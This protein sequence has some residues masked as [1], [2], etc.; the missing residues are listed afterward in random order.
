MPTKK[1]L[2]FLYLG[3]FC[4]LPYSLQAQESAPTTASKVSLSCTV[5]NAVVGENGIFSIVKGQGVEL[6]C[7]LVNSTKEKLSGMLLAK[8]NANGTV[9][10]SSSIVNL[11]EEARQETIVSFPPIL[12]PGTYHYSAVLMGNDGRPLS[13]D[14][15]MTGKLEGEQQVS[16]AS[17]LLDKRVYHWGDMAT[18]SL[19]LSDNGQGE[20]IFKA[21]ELTLRVSLLDV[22]Q[23]DCSVLISEQSV[24]EITADYQF[25]LTHEENCVNAVRVT[26]MGKDGKVLDQKILAVSF[27][28]EESIEQKALTE[29]STKRTMIVMWGSIAA[30]VVLLT[31]FWWRYRR[32]R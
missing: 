27:P 26:L 29:S 10:A 13:V 28:E 6:S 23:K 21:S 32:T 7:A 12:L 3:I 18:L 30:L 24:T 22:E 5:K 2:S 19:A 25:E 11:D 16:I 20:S 17:A 14:V 15:A 8:Q 4:V 31:Y 9:S 1:L